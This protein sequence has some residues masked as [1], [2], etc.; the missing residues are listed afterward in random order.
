MR[1]ATVILLACAWVLASW[2]TP[3]QAQEVTGAPMVRDLDARSFAWWGARPMSCDP[4]H[5]RTFLADGDGL[6]QTPPGCVSVVLRSFWNRAQGWPLNV[7]LIRAREQICTVWV[8]KWG[9]TAWLLDWPGSG[10]MMD[11]SR[12]IDSI[13]VPAFC[14]RW[15]EGRP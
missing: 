10:W 2:A 14:T 5:M 15:A 6:D 9:H 13:P 1:L 8:H 3:A 4:A 7:F 11:T 12:G